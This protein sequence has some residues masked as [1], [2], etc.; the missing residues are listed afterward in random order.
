MA[1]PTPTPTPTPTHIQSSA[2]KLPIKRKT[3]PQPQF[4]QSP[5]P[6][7]NFSTPLSANVAAAAPSEEDYEFD[8]DDSYYEEEPHPNPNPS[9]HP[10]FKFHRIWSEP[11]ELR[12]LQGLLGCRPQGLVFP[13][14]LNLFYDRFSESMPQPYTRSQLSEKLRRLRKKYRSLSARIARG[15]QDPSR[16]APH[17]RDLLHLC[18]R[19]WHPDH[20]S[21]SP[22]SAP[23][24]A[25]ATAAAGGAS[26]KGNRRRRANPPAPAPLPPPPGL[27]FGNVGESETEEDVPPATAPS[28]AAAPDVAAAGEGE[29]K[30]KMKHVAARTVL[31]VFDRALEE[32]RTGLAR[33]DDGGGSGDDGL[34]RR[35][36]EQWVA[37]LDVFARRLRLMLEQSLG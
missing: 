12:F 20:A 33:Q 22:F 17:D 26:S 19:L 2:R 36:R 15:A 16:L 27:Q 34:A 10:P 9:S 30:T 1:T 5:N 28:A 31:D 4:L 24:V 7:P 35:W 18:T 14:D 37:E 29:M 8:D 6:N 25:A 21:A 11:D 13:R 3:P 23:D 32:T